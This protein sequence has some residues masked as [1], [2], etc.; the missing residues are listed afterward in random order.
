MPLAIESF[1]ILLLNRDKCNTCNATG[2]ALYACTGCNVAVY[3]NSQCQQYHYETHAVECEQIGGLL[4][5]LPPTILWE[6]SRYLSR[7]DMQNFKLIEKELTRKLGYTWVGAVEW[8]CSRGRTATANCC[9]TR[10]T[11]R[12]R[13]RRANASPRRFGSARRASRTAA[14]CWWRTAPGAP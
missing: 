1:G 14:W 6:I 9:A 7:A 13:R 11:G 2:A 3:C 5:D 12:T 4:G 8:A 10:P